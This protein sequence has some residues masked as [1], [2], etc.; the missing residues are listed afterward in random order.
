MEKITPQNLHAIRNTDEKSTAKKLFD[1]T[2]GLTQEQ[3][4]GISGVSEISSATSPWER[5]SL[6]NDEEIINLSKA[7][8]S[9][10]SDSVLCLGKVR[11]FPQSNDEW[12]GQIGMV[13]A[14]NWIES[15]ENQWSSSG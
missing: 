1:V 13:H 12:R 9:V 10:I 7:K 2:Q 11:P 15:M 8:V 5:L 6:V 3:R 14:E 4:L